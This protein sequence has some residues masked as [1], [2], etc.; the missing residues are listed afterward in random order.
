MAR[1]RISYKRSKRYV[2]KK[3]ASGVKRYHCVGKVQGSSE[4]RLSGG[5]Y[6]KGGKRYYYPPKR[7]ARAG[8]AKNKGRAWRGDSHYSKKY[9]GWI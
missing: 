9:K 2:L 1:R 4:P 5:Y 3:G 6:T 8:K 7:D